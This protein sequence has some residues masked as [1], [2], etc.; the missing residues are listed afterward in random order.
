L[1]EQ[2][3]LLHNNLLA[4]AVWVRKTPEER[5]EREREGW[6]RQ[7]RSYEKYSVEKL[8]AD[9]SGIDFRSTRKQDMLARQEELIRRVF[10]RR[11]LLPANASPSDARTYQAQLDTAVLEQQLAVLKN[12]KNALYRMPARIRGCD[13]GFPIQPPAQIQNKSAQGGYQQSLVSAQYQAHLP[14]ITRTSRPTQSRGTFELVNAGLVFPAAVTGPTA[15]TAVPPK[16]RRGAPRKVMFPFAPLRDMP[17]PTTARVNENE[18]LRKFPEHLS[19]PEVMRRFVRPHGAHSGGWET[20]DMVEGLLRHWNQKD[21]LGISNAARRANLSAWVVKERDFTNS[22]IRK[23][24]GIP[25][26]TRKKTSTLAGQQHQHSAT[27]ITLQPNTL[28]SVPHPQYSH[29][30]TQ[31]TQNI[32]PASP[33][34]RNQYSTTRFPAVAAYQGYGAKYD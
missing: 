27:E 20:K 18:V 13:G 23:E 11:S 29:P 8:G 22:R 33:N 9:M 7:A 30:A 15:S 3:R 24:L 6:I 5:I 16:K 1:A 25:K 12:W 14:V 31:F 10:I 26:T 21:Q 2:E 4:H 17:L 19:L 32:N 34:Q 28:Q